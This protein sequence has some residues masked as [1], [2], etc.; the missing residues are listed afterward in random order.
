VGSGFTLL[1]D[2]TA[3]NLSLLADRFAKLPEGLHQIVQLVASLQAAR[4]GQEPNAGACQQ[5]GLLAKAGIR[6]GKGRAEGAHPDEGDE[7]RLPLSHG[8]GE[9]LGAF[10]ELG[11]A[12]FRGG[13]R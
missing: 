1:M 12:K 11:F 3:A 5:R 9:A 2:A 10:A 4:V 13:C 6:L 8:L 7:S